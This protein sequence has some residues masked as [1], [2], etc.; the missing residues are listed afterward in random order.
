LINPGASTTFRVDF[1]PNGVGARNA[2]MSIINNDPDAEGS[3]DINL[4]GTATDNP[5]IKVAQPASS[6]LNSGGS[7]SYGSVKRGLIFAKDFTITN[8]GVKPLKNI[9]VSI[10][11]DADFTLVKP[12]VS[13]LN[14]GEN[15]K[16]KVSFKPSSLGDKT[17]VVKIKSND[18][19]ENPFVINVSGTG[20]SASSAAKIALESVVKKSS[21][22]AQD[23]TKV[24]VRTTADGISYLVLTV[25]KSSDWALSNRRVEVSG[26]LVD[27]YSGK[28]HTKVLVDDDSTLRVQ[29]KTP[30]S[31]G[32]KRY[33]RLK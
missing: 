20:I 14:S 17:A 16:F 25:E 27:W 7:R 33:I 11:G 18:A 28:K 15:V 12:T 3:F 26:N 6:E 1:S 30:V 32:N 10:S 21:A 5:E 13:Q 8:V 23:D 19:D 9:A 4:T 24:T 2:T 29:D 22:L 31:P